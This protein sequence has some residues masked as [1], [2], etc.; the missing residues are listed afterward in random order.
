MDRRRAEGAIMGGSVPFGYRLEDG[1]KLRDEVALATVK[2]IFE[3]SARGESTYTIAEFV[4]RAGYY[5]RDNTIPDI[6]R[7]PVYIADGVVSGA[8]A[9]KAVAALESRRTGKVRRIQV[10]DYSGMIWCRCGRKMH[11]IMVGGMPVKGIEPT[12]YYRCRE[13]PVE[14]DMNG[15]PA[16]D[17]NGKAKTRIP[18]VRAD[19]TDALVD[20]IMSSDSNPWLIE[21]LTGGDTREADKGEV[22]QEIEKATKRRDMAKVIQLN[23]EPLLSVKLG[24]IGR[25]A[26]DA[27]LAR[28]IRD[29]IG[30]DP[31]LTEKKMFGGLA[32]L[33]RGHL[34]ISAS[35]QGGVM[36]R[37][38]PERTEELTAGGPVTVAVMRGREMPGWLRVSAED[39]ATDDELSPWVEIGIAYARSLPPKLSSLALRISRRS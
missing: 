26:Y 5:R 2:E 29:I 3:R 22:W 11:R 28:R 16:R 17:E 33:V 34:A 1:Q 7:N 27:S 18:M 37:A 8:L 35:G 31:E 24:T 14:R 23:A 36:F 32:F 15:K 25:M 9:Q 13:H 30:P 38:D 6:L 20:I 19:D 12:R 10:E 21:V 4:K 39:V